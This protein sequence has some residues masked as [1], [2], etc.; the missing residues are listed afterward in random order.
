[1]NKQLEADITALWELLPLAY[2]EK[3]YVGS[4]TFFGSDIAKAAADAR[5]QLISNDEAHVLSQMWIY[6]RPD[7]R[8][9]VMQ[10]LLK[11]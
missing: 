7:D 8:V 10:K 5:V 2:K 9:M 6:Q 4:A 3:I 1:M 11:K